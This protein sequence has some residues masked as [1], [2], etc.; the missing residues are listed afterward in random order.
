MPVTSGGVV[1]GS[2]TDVVIVASWVWGGG[3]VGVGR[4]FAVPGAV[5]RRVRVRRGWSRSSPRP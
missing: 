3:V 2:W 1:T 4:A 5:V